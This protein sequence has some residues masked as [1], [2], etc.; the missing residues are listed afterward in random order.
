[1]AQRSSFA[2]YS[3]EATLGFGSAKVG[4]FLAVNALRSGRFLD[5][6]ELQPIHAIG[7]SGTIFDHFDYNPNGKDVFHLNILG[8]RNWFQIPNTYDQLGQDQRQK[9][10]TFNIAPGYQHIFSASTLLTINPFYRADR[11]NYYP[12]PDITRRHARDHQPASDADQ[13]GRESR[14][15]DRQRP[16]Q[17]QSRHATDADAPARAVWVWDHR[18][19]RPRI[20]GRRS[21]TSS[22]D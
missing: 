3:E 7:N 15:R 9:I 13:L 4:N 5:T 1:M 2:T 21:E 18:S 22:L 10:A 6:P 16:S 14:S 19:H 17:F 12:S 8:A 20:P 11:V